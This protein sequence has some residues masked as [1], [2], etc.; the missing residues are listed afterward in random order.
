MLGLPGNP[1]SAGVTATLFLKPAIDVMLGR[2]LSAQPV[3]TAILTR[4]LPGNDRRQDYLRSVLGRNKAG[5]LTVQPFDK[6]DSSMLAVF[7]SA[8]C[9]AVRAP[10]AGPAKIGDRI[11]IVRLDPRG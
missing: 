9:L 4:D 3:E 7:S 1:V 8:D 5:D 10:F 6:Q 2:D 11:E